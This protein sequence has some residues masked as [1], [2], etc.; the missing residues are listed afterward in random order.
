MG[1]LVY[2]A[3]IEAYDSPKAVHVKDDDVTY[4][5][6][7]NHLVPGGWDT[8]IPKGKHAPQVQARKIKVMGPHLFPDHDWYLW[9]DA[10]MQIKH[11][12]K[13]LIKHCVDSEHDFAAF[14]HNEFDCAYEE[15]AACGRRKKDTMV[16]LTKAGRLLVKEKLPRHFGQAATGILFRKNTDLVLAHALAWWLDMQSTTMRDQ[17]T[18]MLN[19]KNHDAYVEWLPGLHTKNKWFDYKRGHLK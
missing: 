12:I 1:G 13:D 14:K 11:S 17:C 18:F 7:S 2:S 8:Y 3:N 5:M 16:N 15:I 9:L 4:L 19:V 10:T 6:A